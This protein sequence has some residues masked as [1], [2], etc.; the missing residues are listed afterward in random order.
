MHMVQHRRLPLDELF[1][2]DPLLR[3]PLDVNAP[4]FSSFGRCYE[5]CQWSPSS[6]NSQTTRCAAVTEQVGGTDRLV[7]FD[8]YAT[9]S[10]RYYAPVGLGIWCANWETGCEA[11]GI[12]GQFAVLGP[13]ER[14]MGAAPELSHYDVSWILDGD[15]EKALMASAQSSEFRPSS[16]K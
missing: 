2:S 11:L 13:E 6:F 1:F 15:H 7:R 3:H 14:G 4:P 9:T 5:I 16:P 10:S 12:S 8:F